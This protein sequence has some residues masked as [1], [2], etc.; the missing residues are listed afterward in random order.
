MKNPSN[1]STHMNLS[2]WSKTVKKKIPGG[3]PS[4]FKVTKQ[5]LNF[6]LSPGHNF[7]ILFSIGTGAIFSPPAVIINSLYLP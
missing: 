5:I 1:L 7:L 4:L 2:I 3:C 6:F